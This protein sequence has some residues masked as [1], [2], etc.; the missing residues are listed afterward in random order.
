MNDYYIFV[1]N[2]IDLL[3]LE[4]LQHSLQ[5]EGNF[6]EKIYFL[7]RSKLSERKA[8]RDK[9]HKKTKHFH[10]RNVFDDIFIEWVDDHIGVGL[11]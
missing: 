9:Y 1:L 3:I 8:D 7:P 6:P 5:H 11:T 2:D 4:L 10:S